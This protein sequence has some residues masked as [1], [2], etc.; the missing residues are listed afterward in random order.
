VYRLTVVLAGRLTRHAS[1][2]TIAREMPSTRLIVVTLGMALQ[3]GT[4]DP[5]PP[6]AL[7]QALIEHVCTAKRAGT[8]GTDA[9]DGCLSAQLLSLRADFGRDLGRLS[10][11]ERRTI[12]SVC[13]KVNAARGRDAYLACLNGQLA[14]WRDRWRATH[15]APLDVSP[16]P[17]PPVSAA[18]AVPI[19]PSPRAASRSY[20]LWIG[21]I[22][23][24]VLLAAGGVLVAKRSRRPVHKCKVC[25]VDVPDGGELCQKCRHEAAEGRRVAAVERAHEFQTKIEEQRVQRDRE[26]EQRRERARQDEER[27]QQERVEEEARRAEEARQR[28]E[29]T[30][31]AREIDL[32]PEAFD[33]YV[34]LGVGRNATKEEIVAAYQAAKSKYDPDQLSYLSAELQEIFKGKAQ[35]V[36]RAYQMLTA[37][38]GEMP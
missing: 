18:S 5:G 10:V 30:R 37:Q 23:V 32:A 11:S 16:S 17:T 38:E 33:P 22:V 3:L 26:E 36:D 20:G 1:R 7:E 9:Y 4:P 25:G 14:S 31:V 19:S 8:P 12:D 6:T 13:S 24:T 15:P 35:A 29:E 34:V 21:V 2:A 27:R 28:D